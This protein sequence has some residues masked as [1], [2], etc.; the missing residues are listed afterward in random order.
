MTK[1]APALG[2]TSITASQQYG[3]ERLDFTVAG[4]RAFMI[5]PAQAG[6]SAARPWLWYQPALLGAH[7]ADPAVNPANSVYPN[8]L[9]AWLFAQ[10]LAQGFC[11]AGVETGETYGNHAGRAAQ[12]AFYDAVVPE[13]HLSTKA[14]LLPQSRGG[15][16]H[17]NWAV[18]HPERVQCVGAI[19]PVT[20][21]H[22]WVGI[23]K[24]AQLGYGLAGAELQ[25]HLDQYSPV[26]RLAPLAQQRVPILHVH[27]DQD[28]VVPA[29]D[30]SLEF[31]RR[32]RALGGQIDIVTVPGK[33]H[34][35]DPEFFQSPQ[36]LALFLAQR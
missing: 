17:Y 5:L 36:M 6:S 28:T 9:H 25:A 35:S 21:I 3:G 8:D 20:D 1:I 16:M 2:A 23:D 12:T 26:D 29:E 31:A 11:I 7:P 34:T 30:N 19:Y 24:I 27:G 33:G 32:Y 15:L 22:T 13:F 14:C 18:E 4:K 10:L